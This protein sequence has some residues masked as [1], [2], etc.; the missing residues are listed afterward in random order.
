[1]RCC[2]THGHGVVFSGVIGWIDTGAMARDPI[3]H[4][5]WDVFWIRRSL[6]LP[7]KRVWP[8]AVP[9]QPFL[10]RNERATERRQYVRLYRSR[11]VLH[12]TGVPSSRTETCE[13]MHRPNIARDT[14]AP[15]SMQ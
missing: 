14:V 6:A 3:E 12:A 5:A 1:M 10:G 4:V 11:L 7:R 9:G 2:P 13:H 15:G 8:M